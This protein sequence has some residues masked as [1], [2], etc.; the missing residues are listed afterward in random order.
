MDMSLLTAA[1]KREKSKGQAALEYMVVIS[2]AFLLAAPVLLDAQTSA[3][4]LKTS[5]RLSIAR[6]SLNT[7]ED[8][9]KIVHSQGAPARLSFTIRVPSQ[10]TETDI[11]G[12]Q[13]RMVLKAY[14]GVTEVYNVFDFNV[15]G[16]LP[17]AQGRYKLQAQAEANY[18]NISQTS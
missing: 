6:N 18:V 4:D 15:S 16:S 1:D 17:T 10:V 13:V 3:R 11:A 8:A 9:A 5:A 7:I 14:G 2:F 12:K